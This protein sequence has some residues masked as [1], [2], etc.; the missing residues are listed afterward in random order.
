MPGFEQIAFWTAVILGV[1]GGSIKVVLA[2]S[3]AI[4]GRHKAELKECQVACD[5]EK[6]ILRSVATDR[7]EALRKCEEE[8]RHDQSNAHRRERERAD[9]REERDEKILSLVVEATR[10][11]SQNAA[12]RGDEATGDTG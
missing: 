7:L 3:S 9:R 11:L 2:W 6:A 4:H 12:G 8:R 5:K 1:V 10:T